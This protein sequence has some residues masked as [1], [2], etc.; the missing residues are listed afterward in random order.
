M[1]TVVEEHYDMENEMEHVSITL[2][3]ILILLSLIDP[4]DTARSAQLVVNDMFICYPNR[5][6]I[7]SDFMCRKYS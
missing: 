5:R 6:F 4:I 1:I 3:D 2:V 7:N